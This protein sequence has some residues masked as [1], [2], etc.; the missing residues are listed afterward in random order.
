MKAWVNKHHVLIT[1][2]LLGLL[3][4]NLQAADSDDEP[5]MELLEFLGEWQT[6][7]G[8][9]FDP[10]NLLDVEQEEVTDSELTNTEATNT[11]V[12]TEIEEQA[13]E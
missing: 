12:T 8:K 3:A 6:D 7:D 10:L 9:W 4:D 11:E 5:S 13:N 2:L 1:M